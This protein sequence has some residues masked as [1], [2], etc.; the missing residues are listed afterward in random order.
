MFFEHLGFVNFRNLQNTKIQLNP[1]LNV[2]IGKNG[3]GKSNILEA[4]SLLVSGKSFRPYKNMHIINKDAHNRQ[5]A[6]GGK[7]VNNVVKQQIEFQIKEQSKYHFLDQKKTSS[8][9]VQKKYPMVIFSPESLS[10]IKSGPEVRR[11]LVDDWICLY[12]PD[13][14]SVLND[15]N[16]ALKNRNRLLKDYKKEKIYLDEFEPL[17]DS[18]NHSFYRLGTE[19]TMLRIQA[20]KD[21]HSLFNKAMQR[22]SGSKVKADLKYIVSDVDVTGD[23]LDNLSKLLEKRAAELRFPEVASG[24]SLFGP[25]KHDILI[26]YDGNDSRYF[27][28]QGQQRALI[29]SFKI[30]QIV[31][32]NARYGVF[33]LRVLD[34]V[35]SELDE[36]K[37]SFLVGFLKEYKAQTFVTT[38][39]LAEMDLAKDE[40]MKVFHLSDGFVREEIYSSATGMESSEYERRNEFL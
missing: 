1:G 27:C 14:I 17:F 7:L 3:Q 11:S 35:L 28:S 12:R 6:V 15:F 26:Q 23:S 19:L 9:F 39:E 8:A 30:A 18:L 38:T 31:Y 16:K 24:T 5:C 4:I 34:D 21:I 2:F 10:A 33:P 13:K 36:E 32:Y 20:L 25:Q 37:R 29:L 40:R 22:I